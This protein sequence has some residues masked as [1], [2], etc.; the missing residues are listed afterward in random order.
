MEE[1][2]GHDEGYK[3]EVRRE[4]TRCSIGTMNPVWRH[5]V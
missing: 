1:H 3:Y 2:G 5:A 4:K